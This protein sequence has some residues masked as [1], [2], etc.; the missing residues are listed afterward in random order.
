VPSAPSVL[1]CY[2]VLSK[3][4]AFLDQA[5]AAVVLTMNALPVEAVIKC[6]CYVI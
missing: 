1:V 5:H 6:Q 4:Y 3:L 2:I